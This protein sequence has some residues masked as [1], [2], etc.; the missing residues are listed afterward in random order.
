MLDTG[1]RSEEANLVPGLKEVR[2]YRQQ[3]KPH[4]QTEEGE[5]RRL[6]GRHQDL[7]GKSSLT[8]RSGQMASRTEQRTLASKGVTQVLGR[9]LKDFVRKRWEEKGIVVDS[10]NK[11]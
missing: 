4:S 8:G 1:P 6:K 7:S 2:M 5:G 11:H 3:R 10:L 9:K